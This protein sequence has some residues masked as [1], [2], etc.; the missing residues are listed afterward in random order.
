MI[1]ILRQNCR[2]NQVA[3]KNMRKKINGYIP[4]FNQPDLNLI[5]LRGYIHLLT[6]TKQSTILSL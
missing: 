2:D 4:V 3:E 1:K 6:P 5:N